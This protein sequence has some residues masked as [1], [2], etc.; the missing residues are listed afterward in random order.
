MDVSFNKGS[1]GTPQNVFET[2]RQS[3]RVSGTYNNICDIVQE[4]TIDESFETLP[5]RK[6]N[7][8]VNTPKQKPVELP[9]AKNNSYAFLLPDIVPKRRIKDQFSSRNHEKFV[10]ADIPDPFLDTLNE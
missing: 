7:A 6:L 3:S 2:I 8:I 9:F 5:T 1:Q 4:N 10:N